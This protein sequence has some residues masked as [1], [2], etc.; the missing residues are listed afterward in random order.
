M[1]IERAVVQDGHEHPVVEVA[2]LVP[3]FLLDEIVQPDFV[4]G[5]EGLRCRKS[6][7]PL[8]F[9]RQASS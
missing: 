8:P 4:F 9:G 3:A 6:L 1:R 2:R 7:R 5:D